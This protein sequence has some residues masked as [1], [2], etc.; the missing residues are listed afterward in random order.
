MG[1]ACDSCCCCCCPTGLVY[2]KVNQNLDADWEGIELTDDMAEFNEHLDEDL[3]LE[4]IEYDEDHLGDIDAEL[5]TLERE[6]ETGDSHS[7][8]DPESRRQPENLDPNEL[9]K[10]S[11]QQAEVVKP[12]KKKKMTKREVKEI[13]E[14]ARTRL[15]N[16]EVEQESV[17]EHTNQYDIQ[18][19]L[20][21]EETADDAEWDADMHSPIDSPR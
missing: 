1:Q 8:Q 5:E 15:L 7:Q 14:R 13:K 19:L 18:T 16:K 9:K 20:D 21:E 6:A 2:Q 17:P 10:H 11:D 3:D 12:K 4:D